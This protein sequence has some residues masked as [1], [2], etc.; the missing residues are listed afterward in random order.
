[1]QAH[2][3]PP[4]LPRRLL[5]RMLTFSV[6]ALYLNWKKSHSRTNFNFKSSVQMGGN[7]LRAINPEVIRF[8]SCAQLA[9]TCHQDWPFIFPYGQQLSLPFLLSSSDLRP[10]S[11]IASGSYPE[12]T[13]TCDQTLDKWVL[14]SEEQD[15]AAARSTGSWGQCCPVHPLLWEMACQMFFRALEDRENMANLLMLPVR[16]FLS[17]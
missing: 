10:Q 16:F 8:P 11:Y 13:P 7:S 2:S 17:H 5:K 14:L 6:V 15:K 4:A 9:Q 12:Q 1:M 3:F